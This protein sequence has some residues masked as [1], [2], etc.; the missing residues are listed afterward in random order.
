MLLCPTRVNRVDFINYYDP[1]TLTIY[2]DVPNEYESEELFEFTI[3]G[4]NLEEDIEVTAS[5]A[6]PSET[7]TLDPGFYTVTETIKDGYFT[8]EKSQ[9]IEIVPYEDQE[10]TFTNYLAGEITIN[11]AV[12]N[13]DTGI[14]FDFQIYAMNEQEDWVHIKTVH[15]SEVGAY[16]GFLPNGYYKIVELD[17]ENYDKV[18]AE[19]DNDS[20]HIE[21]PEENGNLSICVYVVNGEPASVTFHNDRKPDAPT[22]GELEIKKDVTNVTDSEVYFTFNVYNEDEELVETVSASEVDS[23]T[24]ELD[25]GT[26]TVIEEG[27][28]GY[29]QRDADQTVTIEAGAEETLTFVNTKRAHEP[30]DPDDP[31]EPDGPDEPEYEDEEGTPYNPPVIEEPVEEPVVEEVEEE[32]PAAPIPDTDGSASYLI[33]VLGLALIA[34]GSS[35]IIKAYKAK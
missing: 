8:Y 25:P 18:S 21:Y 15:A 19:D 29:T 1:A 34:F 7:V 11:K 32:I 5:E 13:Y 31:D 6:S 23:Y 12:D 17:K 24:L 30:H 20:N 4:D 14:K 16:V 28:S 10:I 33:I 22:T 2:K 27:R 9:D 3:S 26:Y 35:K